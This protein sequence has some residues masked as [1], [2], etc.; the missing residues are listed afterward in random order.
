MGR[1]IGAGG[2]DGKEGVVAGGRG[3]CIRGEEGCVGWVGEVGECMSGGWWSEA[4]GAC[5]VSSPS[6]LTRINLGIGVIYRHIYASSQQIIKRT[7]VRALRIKE[8]LP[9][10]DMHSMIR[11]SCLG[12]L[13]SKVR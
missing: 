8:S 13:H 9:W 3:N 10:Q 11:H 2:D 4:S 7:R 5:I 1:R 12:H 6:C